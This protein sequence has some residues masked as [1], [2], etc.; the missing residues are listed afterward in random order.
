[1]RHMNNLRITIALSVTALVVAFAPGT[2]QAA[3][4]CNEASN[5]QRGDLVATGTPDPSTPA[6]HKDELAG[7]PGKG[8]GLQNAAERSPALTT[9][10]KPSSPVFPT[11]DGTV[12]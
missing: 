12:F 2:A 9:C 11:D 3:T 7:I 8:V 5:S 6:R 1:M 10:A 4:V